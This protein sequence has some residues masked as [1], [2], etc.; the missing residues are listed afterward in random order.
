MRLMR[1]RGAARMDERGGG[2]RE[3]GGERS[4]AA[5]THRL[6]E[7]GVLPPDALWPRLTDT[8]KSVISHSSTLLL[9]CGTETRDEQLRWKDA[10]FLLLLLL[11]RQEVENV[12]SVKTRSGPSSRRQTER[13]VFAVPDN[14]R[15][16]A[17]VRCQAVRTA[18]ITVKRSRESLWHLQLLKPLC[19]EWHLFVF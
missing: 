17:H 6:N 15:L 18:W 7:P 16:R 12:K 1:S 10:A 4:Q 3:R 19:A 13:K 9:L 5:V 14:R 11:F 8:G 2:E